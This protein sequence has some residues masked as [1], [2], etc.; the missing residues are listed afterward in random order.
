MSNPDH[1]DHSFENKLKDCLT[2]HEV[3]YQYLHFPTS[4]HSVQDAADSV[5]ASVNDCI[6]NIC[7]IDS[8]ENVIVAIVK[9]EHRTSTTRVAKALNISRPRVADPDEIVSRIGYPCGGVPA[10]GFPAIFL[11]DPKVME[12]PTVYTSGGSDKSLI[13][14]APKEIQRVNHAVVVRVRK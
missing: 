11:I 6:K 10:F 7:M 12:K 1:N 13:K 2:K 3:D 5:N 4:C 8:D 14:I 9:G